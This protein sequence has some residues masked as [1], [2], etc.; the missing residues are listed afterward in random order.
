MTRVEVGRGAV[1]SM[2]EL[3]EQGEEKVGRRL[4]RESKGVKVWEALD[5]L[6]ASK[7][8]KSDPGL[9]HKQQAKTRQPQLPSL[10]CLE[11]L[12]CLQ[13]WN[14][15]GVK[16]RLRG[17]LEG[18]RGGWVEGSKGTKTNRT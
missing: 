5:R 14:L 3:Q 8:P 4:R 10:E 12:E 1:G 17:L 18:W 9:E 7:K 2:R 11:C 15:E 13:G 16:W 6:S